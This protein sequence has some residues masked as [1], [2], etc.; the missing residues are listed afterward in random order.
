MSKVQDFYPLTPMQEGMLFHS[1]MDPGAGV[2]VKQTTHALKGE[3][4]I[5]ALES[6]WKELV[7]RHPILRTYFILE[8][9][10]KPVQVVKPNVRAEIYQE[11]W[12]GL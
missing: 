11:D 4:N 9:L 12:S 6:A 8:D 1:L 5:S 10:K 7:A 3:L 2:Y